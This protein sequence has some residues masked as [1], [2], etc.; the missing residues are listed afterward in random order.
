MADKEK[1]YTTTFKESEVPVY[2]EYVDKP[3]SREA[4]KD[5]KGLLLECVDNVE[6]MVY[7]NVRREH[8][9][10]KYIGNIDEIPQII[11]EVDGSMEDLEALENHTVGQVVGSI[12][13]K[14]RSWK[15]VGLG[16]LASAVSA[17]ITTGAF[18][19]AQRYI[20]RFGTSED[21][22]PILAGA[23][24]TA[25]FLGYSLLSGYRAIKAEQAVHR[26][27]KVLDAVDDA[28]QRICRAKNAV[29]AGELQRL[30]DDAC[31]EAYKAR[32]VKDM[33]DI[34]RNF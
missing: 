16:F 29:S 31:E 4:V 5:I 28:K 23:I 17:T 7:G 20:E 3:I 9:N 32:F 14:K 18:I 15:S 10:Y 30:Y 8:G 33:E 11:N 26:E 34:D 2:G 21:G 19:E 13:A 1:N 25:A 24:C 6:G 12:E 27:I 22:G